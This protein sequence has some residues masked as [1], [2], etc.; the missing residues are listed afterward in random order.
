[1]NNAFI[2]HWWPRPNFSRVSTSWS[3]DWVIQLQKSCQWNLSTNESSFTYT[4]ACVCAKSLQLCQLFAVLCKWGSSRLLC[5]WD[6][7]GNKT[8]VGCHTHQGTFPTQR[9]NLC[10]FHLLHLQ[11]VSLSLAPPG[12]P[13]IYKELFNASRK[14]VILMVDLR[15]SFPRQVDKKSRGPQGKR[16]LGYSRRKKGQTLLFFLYIP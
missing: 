3:L 9:L 8:G 11:A 12:K 7:L 15:E 16:G 6:S 13:F 14:K 4:H 10:L 5:P 1:M 2:P